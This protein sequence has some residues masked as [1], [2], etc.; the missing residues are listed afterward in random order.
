MQKENN[1]KNETKSTTKTCKYIL[2]ITKKTDTTVLNSVWQKG[3]R[4]VTDL[5]Y[6]AKLNKHDYV[7]I[8]T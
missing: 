8:R 2:E 4:Q 6:K 7:T 3:Q 1:N 5:Q